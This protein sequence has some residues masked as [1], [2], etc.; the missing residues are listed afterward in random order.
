MVNF[1]FQIFLLLLLFNLKFFS[2]KKKKTKTK[3]LHD[4][5]WRKRFDS[6]HNRKIDRYS[7]MCNLVNSLGWLGKRVNIHDIWRNVIFQLVVRVKCSKHMFGPKISPFLNVSY[8]GRCQVWDGSHSYL[9]FL[10][11]LFISSYGNESC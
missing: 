1:L 11:F 3:R 7:I 8:V 4:N 9:E 10:L 6:N 5:S 2:K